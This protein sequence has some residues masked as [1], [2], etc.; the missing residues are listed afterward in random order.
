[1]ADFGKEKSMVLAYVVWIF[2]G[3]FGVHRM[4]LGR[5]KTGL[6]ILGLLILMLFLLMI[7]G[8]AVENGQPSEFT[9]NALSVAGVGVAFLWFGWYMLDVV[10][11]AVMVRSDRKH[12][13]NLG[14]DH[15]QQVFE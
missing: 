5:M 6:A 4:Y 12:R 10:L 11:I 8:L 13:R 2:L 9:I 14:R 7:L 15:M 1:M 3:H